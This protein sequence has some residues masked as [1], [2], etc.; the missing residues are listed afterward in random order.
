M[1]NVD[2]KRDARQIDVHVA[3][4]TCNAQAFAN[5][6]IVQTQVMKVIQMLTILMK[7]TLMMNIKRTERHPVHSHKSWK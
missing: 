3:R 6:I 7:M 5:A 4:P 1:F 2:V